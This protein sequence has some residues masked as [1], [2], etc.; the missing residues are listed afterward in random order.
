MRCR[1]LVLA[2][3]FERGLFPACPTMRRSRRCSARWPT[4]CE[5]AFDASAHHQPKYARRKPCALLRSD[6]MYS[7]QR[8]T[9]VR[10]YDLAKIRVCRGDLEPKDVEAV[11]SPSARRFAADPEKWIVLSD[12]NLADL[13]EGPRVPAKPY[14]D[15]ALGHSRSALAQFLARLD[16]AKLLT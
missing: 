13:S 3:P 1:W 15:P 8:D 11:L 6:D 4:V 16:A 2:L 12:S 14:W 5:I 7:L 9:H 10:P